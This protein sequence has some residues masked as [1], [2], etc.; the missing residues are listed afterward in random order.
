VD[1]LSEEKMKRL[2]KIISNAFQKLDPW[3][4]RFASSMTSEIEE[5]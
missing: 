4:I 5:R 2:Q 1:G 3:I